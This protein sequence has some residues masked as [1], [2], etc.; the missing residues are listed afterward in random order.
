MDRARRTLCLAL[1]VIAA[2][3]DDH[4][5][6]PDA[7]PAPP[8]ALVAA[9]CDEDTLPASLAAIPAVTAATETACGDYV[10]QPARCFAIEMAQPIDHA[11]PDGA[12]FPQQ[13]FLIHRGCE[14]PTLV[15]DWGYANSDFYDFELSLL[16]QT[17]ALWI[18]HRF[19][20]ASVP[21]PADWDW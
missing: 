13:L 15:A 5:A 7:A 4:A 10:V 14:R 20:G 2:C 6:S 17:N 21:D 12:T 11:T 16:Y 1:L 8:D 18:E 19:Q 9:T 3:S